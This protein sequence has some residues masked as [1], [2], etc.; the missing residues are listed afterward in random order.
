[1]YT[2]GNDWPLTP[3]GVE[4]KETWVPRE[5]PYIRCGRKGMTFEKY[6]A[7]KPEIDLRPYDCE[8]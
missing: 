3:R 6:W 4:L 5:S 1:M 2:A 7:W 8:Y